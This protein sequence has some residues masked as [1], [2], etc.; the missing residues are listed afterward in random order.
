MRDVLGWKCHEG[1]TC[2][3]NNHVHDKGGVHP[4]V[5]ESYNQ[6]Q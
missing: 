4:K 1:C 5:I 3:E 6:K 2:L